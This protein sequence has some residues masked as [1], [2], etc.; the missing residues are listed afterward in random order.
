MCL[1]QALANV[2]TAVQRNKKVAAIKPGDTLTLAAN[3]GPFPSQKPYSR[4]VVVDEITSSHFIYCHE[5][6]EKKPITFLSPCH[7][8]DITHI[9]SE[10]I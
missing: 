7:W 9:N 1:S 3:F 4:T 10:P 2:N 8:P 5:A 6:T